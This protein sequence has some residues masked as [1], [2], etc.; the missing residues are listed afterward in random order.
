MGRSGRP[1]EPVRQAA[2][3]RRVSRPTLPR[4]TKCCSTASVTHGPGGQPNQPEV[5]IYWQAPDGVYRSSAA[6][7]HH[8]LSRSDPAFIAWVIEVAQYVAAAAAGG[9]I[10]NRSDATVVRAMSRLLRGELDDRYIAHLIARQAVER[11]FGVTLTSGPVSESVSV[12]EGAR[13]LEFLS[14]DTRTRYRVV[15]KSRSLGR[16]SIASKVW[17]GDP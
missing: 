14:D 17:R 15:V 16:G 11:E 5:R 1:K 12:E 3:S 7:D 10:G 6:E 4:G 8:E 9:I 13:E 2:A